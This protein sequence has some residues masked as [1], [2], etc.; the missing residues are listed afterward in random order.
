MSG[1]PNN[2][3]QLKK[4]KAKRAEGKVLCDANFHKWQVIKNSKFDVKLGKLVTVER[5]Q[6][7]DKER[8][9]ST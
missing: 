1:P 3:V 8:A 9:R 6:R 7:C 4:V 5:C 2:V